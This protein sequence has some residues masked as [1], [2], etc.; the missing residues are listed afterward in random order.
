MMSGAT[1][2]TTDDA[3]IAEAGVER[4]RIALSA[5][6]KKKEMFDIEEEIA[7]AEAAEQGED[8]QHD[9]ACRILHRDSRGR[10]PGSS[11]TMSPAW[12]TTFRRRSAR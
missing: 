12:S 5:F 1:N 10:R 6:G 9:R 8:Q 11:A 7:A 2:C 4:E 3:Q